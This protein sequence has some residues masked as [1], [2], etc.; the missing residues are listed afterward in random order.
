MY[1]I[2]IQNLQKTLEVLDSLEGLG[3][4]CGG[5]LSGASVLSASTSDT[6]S[7]FILTSPLTVAGSGSD[8]GSTVSATFTGSAAI[9]S[10]IFTTFLPD[11]T[12]KIPT[13]HPNTKLIFLK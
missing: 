3:A 7:P 5:L 4:V 12:V 6:C 2:I 10:S 8:I 11:L 1:F 9:S 13:L